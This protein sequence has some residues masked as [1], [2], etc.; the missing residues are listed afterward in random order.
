MDTIGNFLTSLRNA[1]NVSKEEVVVPYF[2]VS[3]AIASILKEEGYLDEIKKTGKTQP[4]IVI[5]PA[6]EQKMPI[7]QSVRRV[8]KPSLRIYRKAKAISISPRER[9]TFI[10]STPR[11]IMSG[12]EAKKRHLGGEIICQIE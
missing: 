3:W 4:K 5:K 12:R 9:K 11:G 8:S 6:Y 10:I 1:I 7:I 2:K